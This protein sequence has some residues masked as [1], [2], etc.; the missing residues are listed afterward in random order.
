MGEGRGW[1]KEGGG[2]GVGE[3]LGW[4][5]GRG[6]VWDGRGVGGRKGAGEGMGWGEGLGWGEEREWGEGGGGREGGGVGGREGVGRGRGVGKTFLLSFLLGMQKC[7]RP[8]AVMHCSSPEE[9]VQ[10]AVSL[11]LARGAC[12]IVSCHNF[13]CR[14][15]IRTANI[16]AN[17]HVSLL[18]VD[19]E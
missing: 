8:W 7:M 5:E 10:W 15:S 14:D 9:H 1:G 18:A 11:P 16:I 19:K 12:I 13:D 4:G 2:K 3:G 6:W 17:D